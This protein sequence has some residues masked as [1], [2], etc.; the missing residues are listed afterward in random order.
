MGHEQHHDAFQIPVIR[1]ALTR[2]IAA[3]Y[4][5]LRS[6]IVAAFEDLVPAKTDG[7]FDF[8]LHDIS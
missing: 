5:T 8:P 1:S 7:A 2:N 6:E 4:P 3:C